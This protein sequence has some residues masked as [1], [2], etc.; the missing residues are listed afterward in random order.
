LGDQ[1][2]ALE[3]LVRWVLGEPRHNV[4]ASHMYADSCC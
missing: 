1:V 2:G 3:A 4:T